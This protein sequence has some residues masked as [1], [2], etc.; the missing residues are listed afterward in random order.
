MHAV[1]SFDVQEDHLP[2][3][4]TAAAQSTLSEPQR[5][6]LISAPR[7]TDANWGISNVEAAAGGRAQYTSVSTSP[8][9]GREG[10]VGER[11]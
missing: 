10:H 1:S 3:W 6:I 4:S 2:R 7:D 5:T 8:R 11:A 9:L